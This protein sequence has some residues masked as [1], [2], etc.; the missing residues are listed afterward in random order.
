VTKVEIPLGTA[1][2]AAQRICAALLDSGTVVRAVPAGSI[3]RQKPLVGD[4]EVVAE[5]SDRFGSSAEIPRVLDQLGVSHGLPDAAG[6]RAPWGPRYYRAR[7]PTNRAEFTLPL[8]LFVVM[9]PAEWPVIYLI[10]TGSARFSQAFVT[11]LHN[12]NLRTDEGRVLNGGNRPVHVETEED[13][14][15]LAHLPFLAPPQRDLE[16]EGTRALFERA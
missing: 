16:L 5:L 12:Y 3:R 11:R 9:P 6:K 15:R 4:L 13:L 8:D 14:F 7:V 10:R 1:A 2:T